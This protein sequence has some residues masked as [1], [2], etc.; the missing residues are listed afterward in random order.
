MASDFRLFESLQS[1]L[2]F[3]QGTL[4]ITDN[5]SWEKNLLRS[6]WS[7]V[8][9]FVYLL[10]LFPS[11]DSGFC[12]CEGGAPNIGPN[13]EP[14]L[15]GTQGLIGLPGIKGARGDPGSRGASGPAGAP[16]SFNEL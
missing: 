3:P 2:I 13:G 12:A 10:S 9:F 4:S 11:G 7:F 16:V 8:L 6:L 5:H 14:G 15:P 1:P